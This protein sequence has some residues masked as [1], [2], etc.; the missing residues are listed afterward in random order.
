MGIARGR[1]CASILV[2]PQRKTALVEAFHEGGG[3]DRAQAKWTATGAHSER[4]GRGNGK[5][6]RG[7]ARGA[8]GGAMGGG[9][10]G[11]LLSVGCPVVRS[12]ARSC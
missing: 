9:L 8:A 11:A 5:G 2:I 12:P 4:E 6:E 7:T 1:S 3:H 10:L